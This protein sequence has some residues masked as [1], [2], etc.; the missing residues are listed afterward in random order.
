M[1]DML[2]ARLQSMQH[3]NCL[4]EALALVASSTES[5]DSLEYG[6]MYVVETVDTVCKRVPQIELVTSRETRYI[7]QGIVRAPNFREFRKQSIGGQCKSNK[8]E[9]A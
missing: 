7:Q 3:S 5:K 8:L 9:G 1:N 2:E 4:S 6:R